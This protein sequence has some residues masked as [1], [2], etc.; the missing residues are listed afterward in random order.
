MP[1]APSPD[2]PPGRSTAPAAPRR[3]ALPRGRGPERPPGQA[4]PPAAEPRPLQGR[5]S[6]LLYPPSPARPLRAK[7]SRLRAEERVEPH[8]HP[9]AQLAWSAT[10]VLRLTAGDHTY[11]V[12]PSRA[13]W[14]PAGV[15]H[16]VTVV[17]DA[18]LRTLYLH[19]DGPGC[20]PAA[21][22]AGPDRATP[23]AAGARWRSCQVLEVSDLL[24][25]LLLALDVRPDGGPAPDPRALAREAL[26]GPLLAAEL[27]AA[28]PLPL[29]IALPADKRLRRL[30]EAVLD[31]PQRHASL[32]AWLQRL[33]L[34]ASERT[35]ARLFRDEL[36][37]SFLAW[38]QQVL[39]ARALTLA[40]RGQGM[41]RIAAEL[42]YASPSAF[43]AMVRRTL[44]APPRQAFAAA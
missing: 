2:R 24:R 28:P 5:L 44:G 4:E 39:L 33:D 38:R 27:E 43:S 18:E 31:A 19:Q 6:P 25:A 26:I 16:A 21:A 9:W 11:L 8:R 10:G 29:G 34:G 12:P 20:G 42:G 7:R 32:A 30:C 40:A 35:V 22:L 14:I 15:E 41:A 17:E 36:G 1:S 13:V 37:T 23:E 3:P